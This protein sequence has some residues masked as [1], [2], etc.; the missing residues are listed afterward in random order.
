MHNPVTTTPTD[1]APGTTTSDE[2][3]QVLKATFLLVKEI[4]LLVKELFVSSLR[5]VKSTIKLALVYLAFLVAQ[6]LGI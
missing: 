1:S 3:R 6:V 4:L 2:L 5:L